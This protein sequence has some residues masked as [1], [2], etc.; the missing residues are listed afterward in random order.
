MAKK[1]KFLHVLER[2]CLNIIFFFFFLENRINLEKKR[3]KVGY[4]KSSKNNN[5]R[6]NSYSNLNGNKN[7][8]KYFFFFL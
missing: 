4:T 8:K 2:K 7:K 1:K 5:K 3:T 6:L